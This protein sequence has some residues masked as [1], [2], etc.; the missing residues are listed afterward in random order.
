MI[1][2]TL[3]NPP[4]Y[5]AISYRWPG[6]GETPEVIFIDGGSFLVSR[7][8]H[9]LLLAKREHLNQVLVWVDSICI[10]QSD[11]EEKSRQVGMMRRIYEVASSTICWLGD[12]PEA[13]K[14]FEVVNRITYLS[15]PDEYNSFREEESAGWDEFH[16]L[17]SNP[18]FERVWIVQEIAVSRSPMIRYGKE[19]LEWKTFAFAVYAVIL[20]GFASSTYDALYECHGILNVVIM[21]NIRFQVGNED[22]LNL[23]DTLKLGLGFNASLPVDRVYA[24]LGIIEERNTPLFHPK[25]TES[26][27]LRYNTSPRTQADDLAHD[28]EVTLTSLN[29]MIG[30]LSGLFNP[31]KD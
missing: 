25:F 24:Y 23:L 3:K 1:H 18:W 26:E 16:K 5:T 14:A 10:N 7:S 29:V 28:Y 31:R 30:A 2:E 21:E 12:D 4:S 22:Y 17:L 8:I 11:A 15:S 20:F 19:E 13:E 6:A 9:S 27:L